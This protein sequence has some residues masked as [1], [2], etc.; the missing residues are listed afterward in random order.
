MADVRRVVVDPNVLISAAIA[1]GNPQRLV[2]LAAVGAVRLVACP[3]LLEE[4]RRVLARDRFLRWRT[5]GELDRFVADVRQLVELRAD[6]TDIRAST[7]DPDDDYLVALAIEAEV[8]AVCSG[9]LDLQGV[10]DIIVLSPV[11]LLREVLAGA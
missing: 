2:E 5:R 11:E 10:G 1:G 6:P 9:D 7:R 8:D 3:L 4:L